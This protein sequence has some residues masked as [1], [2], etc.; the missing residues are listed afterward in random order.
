MRQGYPPGQLVGHGT[1]GQGL[2]IRATCLSTHTNT[3]HD[4]HIPHPTGVSP[5]SV[6]SA[7]VPGPTPR[8][9]S[10]GSTAQQR[11]LPLSHSATSADALWPSRR[12]L[13]TLLATALMTGMFC[14]CGS[15]QGLG[16][17][18]T[19]RISV[20]DHTPR[21]LDNQPSHTCRTPA[22]S[23]GRSACDLRRACVCTVALWTAPGLFL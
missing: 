4:T 12:G 9:L 19:R 10:L 2:A 21:H 3:P 7:P 20:H 22:F 14:T 8:A 23:R 15:A 5:F 11:R 1:V 17:G 6:A 13:C 16:S 18:I